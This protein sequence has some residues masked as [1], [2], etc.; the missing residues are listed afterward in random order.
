[1]IGTGIDQLRADDDLITA[2]LNASGH[3]SFNFQVTRDYLG[4]DIPRLIPKHRRAGHHGKIR[5][6]GK[7]VNQTFG[8]AVTQVFVIWIF[9]GIYEGQH[10]DRRNL[11]LAAP[12]SV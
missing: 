5:N 7:T 4:I 6:L 9:A 10:S 2:L 8:K 11:L 3:Q 12:A 1:M